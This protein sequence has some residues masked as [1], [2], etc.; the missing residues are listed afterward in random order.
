MTQRKRGHFLLIAIVVVALIGTTL[1][2]GGHGFQALAVRTHLAELDA[3]C[4]QL[5]A[6]AQ[7]WIDHHSDRIAALGPD[8]S[9]TLDAKEACSS[10][11]TPELAIQRVPET[12]GLRITARITSG[13]HA[14]RLNVTIPMPGARP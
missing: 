1:V 10:L 12:N 4:A 5:V 14:A 6:D 11:M 7:L 2:V 8:E 3:A 13:R 9:I